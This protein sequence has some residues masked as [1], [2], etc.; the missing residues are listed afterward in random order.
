MKKVVIL[1]FMI[2]FLGCEQKEKATVVK[3]N[4]STKTVNIAKEAENKIYD[5]F[6]D[7][8]KISPNGKMMI[9]IFGTNTCAYCAKLKQDIYNNEILQNRLKNEFSSYYLK[10]HEN[11]KHKLL[12]KGQFLDVD[13][14]T[15]I[16]VYGIEA[17][18]TI[19]FTDK[20][21]SAVIVVPGYMPIKQFLVTMDFMQKGLWK[22]KDRKNG[23]VYQ[24]LKDYYIKEGTIK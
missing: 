2:F 1:I 15:M 23:E 10:A 7:S 17:T 3:T 6:K 8:A 22:G 20:T 16:S 18:P 24:V 11:L 4:Q 9:L 12:H 13:T 5:V 21:G 14:K 19:I